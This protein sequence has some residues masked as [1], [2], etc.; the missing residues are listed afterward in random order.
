MTN[1]DLSFDLKSDTLYVGWF[2]AS[3]TRIFMRKQR[4]FTNAVTQDFSILIIVHSSGVDAGHRFKSNSKSPE[5][6]RDPQFV[7]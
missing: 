3:H 4:P 7:L 5:V 1:I 2:R 6:Q